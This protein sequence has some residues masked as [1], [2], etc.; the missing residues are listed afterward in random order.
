MVFA[1]ARA[2]IQLAFGLGLALAGGCATEQ[3]PRRPPPTEVEFGVDPASA[4][5]RHSLARQVW[6]LHPDDPVPAVDAAALPLGPGQDPEVEQKQQQESLDMATLRARFGSTILIGPDGTISKQYFLTG[7]AGQVFLNLLLEPEELQPKAEPQLPDKPFGPLRLGGG[8]DSKSILGQMLGDQE[9]EVFYLARF[10]QPDGVAI[11]PNPQSKQQSVWDG[12]PPPVERAPPNNLLLVSAKPDA[13]A[14]FEGALNMFF[15]NVPQIE[16]EVK[17]VEYRTSDTLA[18]GINVVDNETATFTQLSEGRLI[19]DIVSKFPLVAPSFQGTEFMD[20]GIVTL[21]GIHGSWE[22]NAQLQALEAMGVADILSSPRLVVRNG[23]TASVVTRTD[24]PYPQAR[25]SSSG[26]NVTANISFR[27]VGILLNIR[28]VIAGTETVI[29]QVYADISAV[30]SFAETD[31]VDT[32]VVASRKVVTAVHVS[33]GKTT[34]IGGL[35]SQSSIEATS[36]MPLLGDIPILGWLFRST[37]TVR[38]KTTLEFHIT[39]RI[40]RG[41]GGYREGGA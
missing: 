9:V 31:P 32:P 7:E 12:R 2:G 38:E 3:E 14:V 24:F 13:L 36:Q 5:G 23:G 34:V 15:A 39:P 20:R 11:R 30:T 28:P 41:T 21:G 4:T 29:L 16:I 25:I 1:A 6:G 33:D 17:V 27:P 35:V 10:E 22:L 18:F 40:I 26:Q 37:T 8:S 19:N